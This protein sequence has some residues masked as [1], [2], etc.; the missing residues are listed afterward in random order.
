MSTIMFGGR[1]DR[2]LFEEFLD[3]CD[4]NNP[5]IVKSPHM[6]NF[7]FRTVLRVLEKIAN[8]LKKAGF[9]PLT[10]TEEIHA[11]ILDIVEK[12]IEDYSRHNNPTED[13]KEK[14]KRDVQE[15]LSNYF[16]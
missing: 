5:K 14:V 10:V 13:L 12:S 11:S 1:C 16:R 15:F 2:R 3:W 7:M 6:Y 9:N 4:N 8:P